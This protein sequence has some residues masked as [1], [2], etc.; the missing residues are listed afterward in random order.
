MVFSNFQDEVSFQL[1]RP[2]DRH[3]ISVCIAITVKMVTAMGSHR[4]LT[5]PRGLSRV[6]DVE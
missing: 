4:V 5:G 1:D 2:G 6:P 3:Q